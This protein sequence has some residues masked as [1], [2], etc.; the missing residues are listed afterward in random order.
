VADGVR[1]LTR[2]GTFPAKP[3][4]AADCLRRIREQPHEVW[5][6]SPSDRIT[7]LLPTPSYWKLGKRQSYQAKAV[8]ILDALGE[9]GKYLAERLRSRIV[10]YDQY[11]G[12]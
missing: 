9:A 4:Q 1:A 8:T 7:T 12:Q 10:G 11:L 5:M 2:E 3:E 6:V